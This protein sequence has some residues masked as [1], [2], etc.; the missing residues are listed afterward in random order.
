MG[1]DL[2]E[3]LQ[4]INYPTNHIY[5]SVRTNEPAKKNLRNVVLEKNSQV[6]TKE[7]GE[8]KKVKALLIP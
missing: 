6:S 1:L 7:L 8:F 3:T 4:L 5:S 2:M